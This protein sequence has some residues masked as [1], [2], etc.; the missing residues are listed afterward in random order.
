MLPE[1]VSA[2]IVSRP[3]TIPTVN[4]SEV[5]NATL[6]ALYLDSLATLQISEI[7]PTERLAITA[8]TS[9]EAA[10]VFYDSLHFFFFNLTPPDLPATSRVRNV[11]AVALNA[12]NGIRIAMYVLFCC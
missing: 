5:D 6:N 2:V 10:N 9:A 11:N 7:R 12:S 1:D 4:P 8:Q 3:A